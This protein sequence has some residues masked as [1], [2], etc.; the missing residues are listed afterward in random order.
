MKMK[1]IL[2][3]LIGL[4]L[5]SS[6][7]AT[8][9]G[10][11]PGNSNGQLL[12]ASGN[13]NNLV[14]SGTLT[15]A[16]SPLPPE[17]NR[18]LFQGP[19][20]GT[21]YFSVPT[22]AYNSG[23]TG[24][25]SIYFWM[26]SSLAGGSSAGL[27]SLDNGTSGK[28][29]LG[30]AI[31][32]SGYLSLSYTSSTGNHVTA[33]SVS[34]TDGNS[35]LIRFFSSNI[36]GMYLMVDG[37]VQCK[38]PNGLKINTYFY[39]MILGKETLANLY[40]DS[41][42][43]VD[44]VQLGDSSTDPYLGPSVVQTPT[45]TQTIGSPSPTPTNTPVKT[46]TI[47]PSPT[48]TPTAT[49]TYTQNSGQLSASP[50]TYQSPSATQTNTPTIS[51]SPTA[52][53]TGTRTNSQSPTPTKTT[54]ASPSATRTMTPTASPSAT[55]TITKTFTLTPIP[56]YFTMSV[57]VTAAGQSIYLP[58]SPFSIIAV[59]VTDTGNLYS[60]SLDPSANT[61]T[62]SYLFGMGNTNGTQAIIANNTAMGS[63][64]F[65]FGTWFTFKSAS[66]VGPIHI[67][68]KY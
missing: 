14:A 54:T 62:A 11:W 10:Y 63:L 12:D 68:V 41:G 20:S 36:G 65:P 45:L 21:N 22:A 6:A 42:T 28:N 27:L 18:W 31:N 9:G 17:G 46:D 56:N 55:P 59:S 7:R 44:A 30:F 13:G 38:D 24:Q 16:Y 3:L 1:K 19:S 25:I 57:S 33:T 39:Q 53:P 50:T 37:V 2:G 52:S 34:V 66:G 61:V 35:H 32:T 51:Q 47:S 49:P 67:E 29:H 43:E 4:L 8:V 26:Q 15:N 40:T 64:F 5:A 60:Y 48:W 58:Y 23:V